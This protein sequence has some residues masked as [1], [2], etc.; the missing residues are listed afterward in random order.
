M[1]LHLNVKKEECKDTCPMPLNLLAGMKKGITN[2]E[3]DEKKGTAIVEFDEK[4]ISKEE[5]LET[6]KKMRYDVLE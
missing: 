6:I 3:Y 5:V 2:V 1:K 4:T